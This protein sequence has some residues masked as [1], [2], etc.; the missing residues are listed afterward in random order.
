MVGVAIEPSDGPHEMYV[1]VDGFGI[2][3]TPENPTPTTRIIP[4]LSP[5]AFQVPYMHSQSRTV[6]IHTRL[7]VR[8]LGG[9]WEQYHRT[10]EPLS[11]LDQSLLHVP[12]S[13]ADLEK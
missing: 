3:D 13:S 2:S 12:E 5:K 6:L 8:I 11:F 7:T 4:V 9:K 1:R 10:P